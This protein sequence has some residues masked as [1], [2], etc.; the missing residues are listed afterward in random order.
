MYRL[1][2]RIPKGLDP[3][4]AI[5]RQHVCD[6]GTALVKQAED[7]VSSRKVGGRMHCQ[8]LSLFTCDPIH[9]N[10]WPS[11]HP[12]TCYLHICP[13][14]CSPFTPPHVIQMSECLD[15]DYLA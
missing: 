13:S 1:F 10:A 6:E 4:A 14:P 2:V 9:P 7:A 3:I 11:I 12:Y 8:A 5:F 15:S